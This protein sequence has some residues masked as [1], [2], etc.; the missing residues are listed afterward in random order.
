MRLY[1]R[2]ECFKIVG[3]ISSVDKQDL[4]STVCDILEYVNV[5]SGTDD[6]EYCHSIK[7][8]FTIVKFSS[9]RKFPKVLKKKKESKN[10]KEKF[11]LDDRTR[12]FINESPQRIAFII[13]VCGKWGKCKGLTQDKAIF[14]FITI[15]RIIRIKKIEHKPII[16]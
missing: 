4:Q 6:I 15:N 16:T 13:E 14:S 3:F 1:S 2:R 12:L 8:D 5:S 10:C 7:G 11:N 9:I